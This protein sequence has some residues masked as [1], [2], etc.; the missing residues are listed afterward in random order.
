LAQTH[1][2]LQGVYRTFVHQKQVALY[3]S[4]DTRL[5]EKKI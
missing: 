1:T 4:L 3:H 2:D 5:K